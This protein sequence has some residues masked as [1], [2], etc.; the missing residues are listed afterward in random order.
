MKMKATHI[1]VLSLL[2]AGV[3]QVRVE[4]LKNLKLLCFDAQNAGG[5]VDETAAAMPWSTAETLL[6]VILSALRGGGS[7]ARGARAR[8]T[9]TAATAARKPAREVADDAG[10]NS[11]E[12]QQLTTLIARL[13]DLG[14]GVASLP[15]DIVQDI[16]GS[17]FG[18]VAAMEALLPVLLL[19]EDVS[20]TV[21]LEAFSSLTTFH[22]DLCALL[23]S[24]VGDSA[25]T[26]SHSSIQADARIEST[27]LEVWN[28]HLLSM[29]AEHHGGNESAF[30][31]YCSS[32]RALEQKAV[33]LLNEEALQRFSQFAVSSLAQ[34]SWST[35]EPDSTLQMAS[36]SSAVLG[37]LCFDHDMQ[38][39]S[40][41]LVAAAPSGLPLL[42]GI[43]VLSRWYAALQRSDLPQRVALMRSSL[44]AR[45]FLMSRVVLASM[46]VGPDLAS[47]KGVSLSAEADRSEQPCDMCDVQQCETLI[48]SLL[49]DDGLSSGHMK[50]ILLLVRERAV[51]Q[52][53]L[54][55]LAIGAVEITTLPVNEPVNVQ[56][57]QNSISQDSRADTG[58]AMSLDTCVL[59]L[60]A[61]C[62]HHMYEDF[63][64]FLLLDMQTVLCA[65][66]NQRCHWR[67]DARVCEQ[68]TQLPEGSCWKRQVRHHSCCA[69]PMTVTKSWDGST[70]LYANT[71]IF[72]VSFF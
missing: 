67:A 24:K 54:R 41:G 28:Q 12:N 71:N 39:V 53:N 35:A 60:Q 2:I 36:V 46:P 65:S 25:Q 52:N 6:T 30:L 43:Y 63:V 21:A 66:D 18:S 59:V 29:R 3:A 70:F 1:E 47:A 10:T 49:S 55:R 34:L 72:Y 19:R 17:R 31:Q 22:V 11:V 8:P 26:L 32:F 13:M 14:S 27:I 38:W 4:E 68:V 69:G 44:R 7:S 64:Q 61:L 48:A 15:K 9:A 40:S 56:Y 51:L 16:W 42:V 20:P 57:L 37:D 5:G 58:G 50:L 62:K 45:S 23:L 33:E